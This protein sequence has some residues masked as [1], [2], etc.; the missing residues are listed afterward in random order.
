MDFI[1]IKQYMI[2]PIKLDKEKTMT[3]TSKDEVE[4]CFNFKTSR[5]N[6]MYNLFYTN[7]SEFFGN[8]EGMM[9]E[10]M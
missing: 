9:D 3:T 8:W 1:W 6:F 2:T 10:G 5:Y 4:G 7:I